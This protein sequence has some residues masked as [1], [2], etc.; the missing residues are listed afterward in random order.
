VFVGFIRYFLSN[1][2]SHSVAFVLFMFLHVPLY[3]ILS[4]I[5]LHFYF[6]SVSS[7]FILTYLLTYLLT[8]SFFA[9][10]L[11]QRF[12]GSIVGE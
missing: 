1:S 3:D 12:V 6:L 2:V 8:H 11:V 9:A 4:F 7:V 5:L 10:L